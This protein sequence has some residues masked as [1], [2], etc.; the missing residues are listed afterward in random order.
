MPKEYTPMGFPPLHYRA[1]SLFPKI[2]N[3][4]HE[5][6]L[7]NIYLSAKNFHLSYTH[8]SCVK[9]QGVYQTDGRVIPSE[10]SQTKCLDKKA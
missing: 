9:V 4:F 7:D 6:H 8:Q 3:K 5:V 10:V 1:F 2:C